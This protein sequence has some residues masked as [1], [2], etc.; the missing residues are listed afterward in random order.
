VSQQRTPAPYGPVQR[1]P[2]QAAPTPGNRPQGLPGPAT[3]PGLR[4]HPR[5][6]SRRLTS[7]NDVFGNDTSKE[8]VNWPA[9]SLIRNL[10]EAARW[11]RSIRTLQGCP[12]RPRAVGMRG[13]ASQM[14]VAG[15]VLDHDQRVEPTEQHGVHVDEAGR[16]YNAG[17]G[18]QELFPGR[19]RAAGRGIDPGVVQDLPHRRGCDPVAEPDQFALHTPVP[20]GGILSRQADHELADRSCSGPPPGTPA[21]GVVP[22]ACHQLPVSGEQRHGA[23][24]RTPQPTAAEGSAATVQR[25]TAGRPAGSG[26]GRSGG[27]APRS[28]AGA[29]AVQRP[30]TPHAGPAPSR[31]RAGNAQEGR[32]LRRSLRDDPSPEDSASQARSSNRARQHPF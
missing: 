5:V 19:V 24:Q 28:R 31:S 25:A 1:R 12:C 6:P 3:R 9:R 16:D 32:R 21:A 30:W 22:F 20:P 15:S 7:E 23:S 29:P 17:L 11:P 13:D 27:A 10:T 2:A 4:R 18:G 14:D 26:P 8:P